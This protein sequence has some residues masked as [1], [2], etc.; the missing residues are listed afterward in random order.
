MSSVE[1]E[2]NVVFMS[3]WGL[4]SIQALLPGE[5][6][7]HCPGDVGDAVEP[8]E[9]DCRT[10]WLGLLASGGGAVL[11]PVRALRRRLGRTLFMQ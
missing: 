8:V 11:E 10:L 5:R 4:A 2:S 1:T 7:A 9:F 3:R 6:F